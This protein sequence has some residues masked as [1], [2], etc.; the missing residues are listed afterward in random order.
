MEQQNGALRQRELVQEFHE[1]RLLFLTDEQIVR[2]IVE[3][4]RRA[5]E[6]REQSFFAPLPAPLLETFLVRNA[7][8]PTAE[9]LVF[10][11]RANMS[12]GADEGF[13]HEIQAGLFLMEQLERIS[14]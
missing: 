11:K 2:G 9:L 6:F 12:D 13:L 5:R 1:L 7:E 10:S 3:F 14:K 4:G 8:E